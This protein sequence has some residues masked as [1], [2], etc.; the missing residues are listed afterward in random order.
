MSNKFCTSC[1]QSFNALNGCFCMFL[2][3]YVEHC[4]IKLCQQNNEPKTK[5]Q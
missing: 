2:N 3:R 1:K 4:S 5:K